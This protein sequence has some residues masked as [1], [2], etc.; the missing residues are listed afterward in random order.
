MQRLFLPLLLLATLGAAAHAA[1]PLQVR[2][3]W[4]QEA[5]PGATVLAAYLV[6]ANPGAQA[7]TLVSASSPDF[8]AVEMHASQIVNGTA[9]MTPL[10][11]LA[12][13]ARGQ[14]VFAPGG[15]HLMLMRP[16]RALRAGDPVR[17]RLH[18]KDAATLDVTVKVKRAEADTQHHH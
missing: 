5:P 12:I 15:A 8:A 3:A 14:Q 18:F 7:Q 2:D 16:K 6:I 10:K 13:P 17:L 4:V 1:T 11:D 9:S